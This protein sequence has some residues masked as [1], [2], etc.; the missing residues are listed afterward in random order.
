MF[1]GLFF[2]FSL[3][4]QGRY[5]NGDTVVAYF[6]SLGFPDRPADAI[7]LKKLTA[8]RDMQVKNRIRYWS[9]IG[10]KLLGIHLKDV[11][12]HLKIGEDQE[13]IPIMEKTLSS[14]DVTSFKECIYAYY[15]YEIFVD[16]FLRYAE[17]GINTPS[18]PKLAT[19]FEFTIIMQDNII[20]DVQIKLDDYIFVATD[21][22]VQFRYSVKYQLVNPANKAIAKTDKTNNNKF[23]FPHSTHVNSVMAVLYILLI[24]SIYRQMMSDFDHKAIDL[25]DLTV[26]SDRS[27]KILHGDVFRSPTNSS[28]LYILASHGFCLAISAFSTFLY[29]S[30]KGVPRKSGTRVQ[31]FLMIYVSLS[32]VSGWFATA[33]SFMFA[34]KKWLRLVFGAG[35]IPNAIYLVMLIIFKI[36]T[37]PSSPFNLSAGNIITLLLFYFL[38]S[39][40]FCI[41]GGLIALKKRFAEISTKEVAVVPRIIP[42]QPWY[43]STFF[44][45]LIGSFAIGVVLIPEEFILFSEMWYGKN[46]TSFV[47]LLHSIFVMLVISACFSIFITFMR[48]QHENYKW[49]WVSFLAPFC[50]LFVIFAYSVFFYSKKIQI[51]TKDGAAIFF[52][53]SALFSLVCG[54]SCGGIGMYSSII[55][56]RAV[57]SS[58]KLD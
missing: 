20:N 27:W 24:V 19:K 58:S 6:G 51:K 37:K 42:Q 9:T 34:Q 12:I 39:L 14:H 48:L 44:L 57:F 32:T 26:S 30:I 23:Q 17:I 5:K 53:F 15:N 10:D 25:Q 35:I 18:G 8:F 38:P 54:F 3:S 55:F 45:C 41:L 40:G 29:F 31:I 13:N 36:F 11:G 49:H 52:A 46:I 21:V 43:T 47:P 16:D 1:F 7:R 28:L 4:L 2:A 33:L 56:T 22:K 50:S